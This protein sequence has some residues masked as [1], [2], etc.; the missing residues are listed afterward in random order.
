MAISV[1]GVFG[2][3]VLESGE[4][5]NANFQS[6]FESFP[7]TVQCVFGVRWVFVEVRWKVFESSVA[8]ND[9]ERTEQNSEIRRVFHSH[10]ISSLR[11]SQN[12][13]YHILLL[14]AHNYHKNCVPAVN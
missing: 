12:N 3:R 5:R 1:F 11:N 2:L 4:S 13:H 9:L 6:V 14:A 8:K 10:H 7:E